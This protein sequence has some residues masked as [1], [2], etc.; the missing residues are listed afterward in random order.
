MIKL[1]FIGRRGWRNRAFWY[2]RR[3]RRVTGLK[4][5]YLDDEPGCIVFFDILPLRQWHLLRRLA[6]NSARL[7]DTTANPL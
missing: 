4:P 1:K 7:I 2:G 5:W 3:L 6:I